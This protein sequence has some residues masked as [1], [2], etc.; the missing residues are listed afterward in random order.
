MFNIFFLHLMIN[1]YV[2]TVVEDA[3]LVSNH[4]K[5]KIID[6]EDIRL[7]VQMYNE[8]NFCSPP[9]KDV[10]LEV[11]QSRNSNPLPPPKPSSSTGVRLVSYIFILP[12]HCG[13]GSPPWCRGGKLDLWSKGLWFEPRCRLLEK[14]VN[15]DENSWTPTKIIKRE[16]FVQM[17]K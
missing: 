9:P 12:M 13:R 5:K 1:R 8:Q 17:A 4:S 2:T 7:A 14:V 16:A 15:L 10:L 6:N 11:A 3:K